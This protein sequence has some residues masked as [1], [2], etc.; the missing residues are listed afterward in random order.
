M[1]YSLIW[2]LA[3]LLQAG[4]ALA[5]PQLQAWPAWQ[6]LARIGHSS[7]VEL[8]LTNYPAGK[9]QL[10][11][12]SA[13]HR[14]EQSIEL[15]GAAAIKLQLP[16]VADVGGTITVTAAYADGTA[17]RQQLRLQ[18]IEPTRPLRVSA[19]RAPAQEYL[20][21]A[22]EGLLHTAP[23]SLPHLAMGYAG[24]TTLVLDSATLNQLLPE[25]RQ[26]LREFVATCGRLYLLNTSTA[27]TGELQRYAG[28]GGKT[29]A[30]FTHWQQASNTVTPRPAWSRDAINALARLAA[31]SAPMHP[32]M[33]PL[34]LLLGG[35][36]LGLLVLLGLKTQRR[37]LLGWV[38][39]ITALAIGGWWQRPPL[40]TALSWSEMQINDPVAQTTR[41]L[42]LAGRG[43]WRGQQALLE[44]TTAPQAIS[45]NASVTTIAIGANGMALE[46][47]T[48]LFSRQQLSY[49]R[50]RFIDPQLEL[51]MRAA[52]PY[53]VNHSSETLP[54]AVL[55]WNQEFFAIPALAPGAEWQIGNSSG[56][57]GARP[58]LQMMHQR[59]ANTPLALLIN[60]PAE[61]PNRHWLLLRSPAIAA[62]PTI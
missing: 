45:A 42:D 47:A 44:P 11:T 35:Y 39:L 15:S 58:L 51:G 3:L 6:G 13:S 7:E 37:W 48:Q 59:L 29:V 55:W 22:P 25:Q 17:S 24:V 10:A 9:V 4:P 32:A 62:G 12:A 31:D 28:C 21:S 46:L 56:I 8:L 52:R 49:Q 23:D 1:R 41:I 50:Y 2:L 20:L 61:E 19:V 33:L 14:F 54:A 36:L 34:S 30:A 53:L 38:V 43:R 40:R 26:A 57:A 18:L 5:E 60:L 16:F 27:Q